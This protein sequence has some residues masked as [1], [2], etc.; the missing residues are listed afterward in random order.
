MMYDIFHGDS[1]SLSFVVPDDAMPEYGSGY[2]PYI[3]DIG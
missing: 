3:F 1:F 2:S